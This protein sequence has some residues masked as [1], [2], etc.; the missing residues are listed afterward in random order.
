MGSR[1][2]DWCF[3]PNSRVYS[4]DAVTLAEMPRPIRHADAA[5]SRHQ[6]RPSTALIMTVST[7][8]VATVVCV[9][10]ATAWVLGGRNEPTQP[11]VQE[12][13]PPEPRPVPEDSDGQDVESA[14][15]LQPAAGTEEEFVVGEVA[16]VL[17]GASE[18]AEIREV[19]LENLDAMKRLGW[20]VPYLHRRGF[21]QQYA[22]TSKADGVRTL[23]LHLSDGENYINV[24][25]T[26]PEDEGGELAALRAK[27]S[28]VISLED[29]EAEEMQLSTGHDATMYQTD[30]DEQ[31]TSAVETSS[32]QYVVTSDLPEDAADEVTAWVLITDRSRV[33]TEPP[34]PGPTERIERGFNQMRSVLPSS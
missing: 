7:V 24:S 22:E 4:G 26:R 12:L 9:L 16:A 17:P 31:W 1:G 29:G 15:G 28:R 18:S 25:E 8:S 33:Y 3:Q 23:Q 34:S 10:V 13:L 32:V 6:R 30:D 5:A 19:P 14:S 21:E 2:Q 27:L 20:A 11:T